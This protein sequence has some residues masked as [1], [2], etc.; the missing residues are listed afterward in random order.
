M[1]S[2]STAQAALLFLNFQG[3]SKVLIICHASTKLVR[4]SFDGALP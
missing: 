1:Y 4:M 2:I 3:V